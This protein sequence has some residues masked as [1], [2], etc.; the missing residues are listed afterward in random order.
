MHEPTIEHSGPVPAALQVRQITNT[1]WRRKGLVLAVAGIGTLLVGVAGFALPPRYTAVAEIVVGTGGVPA[2]VSGA[3][4]SAAAPENSAIDTQ[5]AMLTSNSLLCGVVENLST[6]PDFAAASLPQAATPLT[7]FGAV[8]SSVSAALARVKAL[9]PTLPKPERDECGR[10]AGAPGPALGELKAGLK[11]FQQ[12]RSLIIAVSFT[13][14]NASQAAIVANAVV[15][16]DVAQQARARREQAARTVEWLDRQLAATAAAHDDADVAVRQLRLTSG[17]DPVEADSLRPLMEARRQL[18]IIQSEYTRQQALL[19]RV[20]RLQQEQADPAALVAALGIAPSPRDASNSQLADDVREAV[21]RLEGQVR[22]DQL[23][24]QAIG[25]QIDSLQQSM[26]ASAAEQKSLASLQQRSAA[27]ARLLDD[28]QRRR[29]QSI[30]ERDLAASEASVFTLAGTPQRPS[31]VG[32]LL[33]IP[34]GFIVFSLLGAVI[35][36]G[37]ERLDRSFR[38]EQ[39]VSKVLGIPCLGLVPEVTRGRLAIRGD[40][41]PSDERPSYQQ[42]IRSVLVTVLELARTEREP[43]I[44]LVTSSVPGEGTSTLARSLGSSAARLGQRVLLIDLSQGRSSLSADGRSHGID[45][46]LMLDDRDDVESGTIR[47]V[48]D[49]GYDYLSG[50]DIGLDL[51][52]YL[53]SKSGQQLFPRLRR[54]Y[55]CVII[56]GPPVLASPETRIM[57]SVADAVVIAVRWGETRQE[58]VWNAVHVLQRSGIA[59]GHV[60]ARLEAVLTRANLPAHARYRHGDAAE[61]LVTYDRPNSGLARL[62][63]A[64]RQLPRPVPYPPRRNRL[65]AALGRVVRRCLTKPES[66]LRT[67][68]A[69]SR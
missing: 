2:S 34:P 22:F 54:R 11:V 14:Q 10:P 65:V 29:E 42:A 55:D 18:A 8:R 69:K 16:Q 67:D 23:Q 6:R 3:K 7:G 38:N 44:V 66:R 37:W 15:E 9:L 26:A 53:V 52:G 13:A 19:A 35:A 46:D 49:R 25:S 68:T 36:V 24:T 64:T 17:A 33:L 61:L 45:A 39:D 59:S 51:L 27:L 1:V 43:R 40:R 62:T 57:A 56:D 31:S 58:V 21:G 48:D 41:S 50:E 32:P 47:Q 4:G 12:R 60:S 63:S 30:Q 28:L 20:R 5:I